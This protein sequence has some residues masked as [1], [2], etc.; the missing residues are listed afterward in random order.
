MTRAS[1]RTAAAYSRRRGAGRE[2]GADVAAGA[3][4]VL[5]VELLAEFFDISA[6]MIRAIRSLGPPGANGT[7]TR[8]GLLG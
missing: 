6:K 4:V 7:I 1:L 2:R 5:D 8:T 3:G